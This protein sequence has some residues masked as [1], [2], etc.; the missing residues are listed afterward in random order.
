MCIFDV[1]LRSEPPTP[2]AAF[3]NFISLT[4]LCHVFFSFKYSSEDD[5]SSVT[6]GS[7][8]SAS[9]T[10]S[11]PRP[12]TQ[13]GAGS[14][15]N[16]T[17]TP[18]PTSH[19]ATSHDPGRSSRAGSRVGSTAHEHHEPQAAVQ[20]QSTLDPLIR[21]LEEQESRNDVLQNSIDTLKVK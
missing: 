21:S 17:T 14:L 6:S 7:N 5:H 10:Q 2:A 8:P 16:V 1:V 15:M 18:H 9:G 3:S 19:P 12:P 11:S 20:P 13:G 4:T